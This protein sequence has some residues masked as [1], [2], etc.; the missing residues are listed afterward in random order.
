[1]VFVGVEHESHDSGRILAVAGVVHLLPDAQVGP[2]VPPQ[3]GT[4][5]ELHLGSVPAGHDFNAVRGIAGRLKGRQ[6]V[7]FLLELFQGHIGDKCFAA[8][9][10]HV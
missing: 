5:I 10:R 4:V 6:V 2:L 7:I 9:A 1:M 8:R 3:V